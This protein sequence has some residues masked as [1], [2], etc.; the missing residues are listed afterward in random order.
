MMQTANLSKDNSD[1]C[2]LY[3]RHMFYEREHN[4][5]K[6]QEEEK[7]KQLTKKNT[8]QRQSK[9]KPTAT[10]FASQNSFDVLATPHTK[11]PPRKPSHQ[12][13]LHS[14]TT[15][16]PA[17]QSLPANTKKPT[18]DKGSK[19]ETPKHRNPPKQLTK[20][21][22][23]SHHKTSKKDLTAQRKKNKQAKHREENKTPTCPLCSAANC[24]ATHILTECPTTAEISVQLLDP[25][26]E[27]L[28]NKK[29]KSEKPDAPHIP[30]T[31]ILPPTPNTASPILKRGIAAGKTP[32]S[33]DN[34][35][36]NH[37]LS[38]Q[39][40]LSTRALLSQLLVER[41]LTIYNMHRK[42]S[43][44]APKPRAR[45][46]QSP[47]KAGSRRLTRC[48]ATAWTKRA[49]ASGMRSEKARASG[50]SPELANAIPR[51][52]QR[53]DVLTGKR[54]ISTRQ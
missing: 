47:V 46:L 32:L 26:I 33:F 20:A 52:L 28:I 1:N 43:L 27:D 24:T 39:A 11:F 8:A 30:L 44:Q 4:R 37:G 40:V 23:D 10:N 29:V 38:T 21:D 7:F 6:K 31:N 34:L 53:I 25:L 51:G 41:S 18:T 15:A 17:I 2:S 49:S 45:P 16:P 48:D 36:R 3:S 9:N 42:L 13:P 5:I 14:Q 35:L 12:T 50:R 22:W 19:S 54:V